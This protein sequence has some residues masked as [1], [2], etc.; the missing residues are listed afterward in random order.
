MREG[1]Q[2]RG[3]GPVYLFAFTVT[4]LALL[5]G[6]G[7]HGGSDSGPFTLRMEVTTSEGTASWEGFAVLPDGTN[8]NL[9]G[10][11]PFSRDFPNQRFQSCDG[12][13]TDCIQA[14][15]FAR[16]S[17]SGGGPLTVCLERLG[18]NRRCNTAPGPDG[19]AFIIVGRL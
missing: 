17:R 8:V 19:D 14:S 9:I 3:R 12:M 16:K 15:A 18:G 10:T 2:G 4:T 1:G 7:G 13:V 6:C 5:A 11:T